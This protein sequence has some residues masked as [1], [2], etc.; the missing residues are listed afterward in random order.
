MTAQAAAPAGTPTTRKTIP[1]D[2]ALGSKTED[3]RLSLQPG[4]N[5]FYITDVFITDKTRYENLAKINGILDPEIQ[6]DLRNVV[7][8]RTTA[9]PLVDQLKDL[10]ARN[11]SGNGHFRLPVGP[12]IVINQ[13][14]AEP[15]PE[16]G[17]PRY[18]FKLVAAPA[19]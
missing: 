2:E 10:A 4:I 9:K 7:K 17:Q 13:E 11:A 15:D 18:Y 14:S 12:V 1:L 5:P 19:K 16:S 8:F 3:D 6:G